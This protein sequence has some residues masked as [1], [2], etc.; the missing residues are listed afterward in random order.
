MKIA[1]KPLLVGL[2]LGAILVLTYERVVKAAPVEARWFTHGEQPLYVRNLQC[3]EQE[4]QNVACT[5]VI[6]NTSHDGIASIGIKWEQLG[7]GRKVLRERWTTLD[8]TRTRPSERPNRDLEGKG[9]IVLD[10]QLQPTENVTLIHLHF[11]FVEMKDGTVIPAAGADSF[12]Y[13]E[14]V[15]GRKALEGSE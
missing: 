9:E 8:F 1:V 15:R 3:R 2:A 6:E 14:L 11:A 13:K 12:I 10:E 4:D 5:A 7:E